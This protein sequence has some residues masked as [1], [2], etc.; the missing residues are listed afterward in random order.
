MPMKTL[1]IIGL[2]AMGKPI[3]Q[4][5]LN[6]G[7]HL[8]TTV[9]SAHSRELAQRLGI[10]ILPAPDAFPA[11]TDTVL[12]LV[13]NY[14]Q[15]SQLLTGPGGLFSAMRSGTVV[16]S[17]TVAPQEAA[18]LS[19]ACPGD[20]ELLDAPVSGGVTGAE[21]GTL[22][23][24]VAGSQ[25]AFDRCAPLFSVYAKKAVYVAEQPGRAQ[26]LKAVNQMLVGIHIVATAEAASLSSALGIDPTVLYDT[27]SDCAGSSV[28]FQNRMPKLI[29][30][31]FSSRAS[32]E[33]LEKDTKICRDLA[34]N[35]GV[36]CFLTE[37][38]NRLYRETPRSETAAEDACAV[39]R[40]Y[41]QQK[42]I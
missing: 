2:G 36:P 21:N 38:C 27:I 31:D 18:D 24:M 23:T 25:E 3:A 11:V 39:I 5:W 9:R 12:L 8:Y 29:R 22:V 28:I 19:A 7:Y 13:S 41:Q 26:A 30:Q 15:C 35:A 4:R 6:A 16:L 42:E 14:A 34:Q 20:V 33:T 32:L 37:I 1:G 17:S 10:E 40:L